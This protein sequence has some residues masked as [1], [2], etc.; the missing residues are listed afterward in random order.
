VGWV[1]GVYKKKFCRFIS[2]CECFHCNFLQPHD[3]AMIVI[4]SRKSGLR[5][6]FLNVTHCLYLTTLTFVRC[7]HTPFVKVDCTLALAK[8][9]LI[10]RETVNIMKN[11]LMVTTK[12][13]EMMSTASKP[14]RCKMNWTAS[15]WCQL[16]GQQTKWMHVEDFGRL[17]MILS[18]LHSAHIQK[19]CNLNVL[20]RNF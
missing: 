9:E 19:K 12:C 3:S 14:P 2:F 6:W 20:P 13:P 4:I 17:W 10:S 1:G 18:R 7:G 8:V 16:S 5:T 15:R 11:E